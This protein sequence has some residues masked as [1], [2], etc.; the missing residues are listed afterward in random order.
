M[1]IFRNSMKT[2]ILLFC[3]VFLSACSAVSEDMPVHSQVTQNK[4][5]SSL[6]DICP[7]KLI[8]RF[9]VQYSDVTNE[10]ER[11]E[12]SCLKRCLR[13]DGNGCFG[14]ANFYALNDINIDASLLLFK[15]SCKL[16]LPSGCTNAAAGMIDDANTQNGQ[17]ILSSFK[18]TCKSKDA[19]GC[20]MQG[21]ML[22]DERFVNVVE[23]DFDAA[24]SALSGACVHGP[25]DPACLSAIEMEALIKDAME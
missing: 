8:K 25:T 2:A 21:I 17:C 9:K 3:V 20:T 14:L 5:L 22:S 15:R 4:R 23:R 11:S 6:E 19:W 10:C 13:G 1:I 18:A 12:S 24:L 7:S 16:G